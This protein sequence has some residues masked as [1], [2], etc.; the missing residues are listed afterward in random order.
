[1]LRYNLQLLFDHATVNLGISAE[2]GVAYKKRYNREF[3][4]F[5]NCVDVS[6]WSSF[7]KS[8]EV[9]DRFRIVY[10]GAATEDKELYSLQDIKNVVLSLNQKGFLVRFSIYGPPHYRN[11]IEKHL[12]FSPCLRA[13]VVSFLPA[14]VS[15]YL[16]VLRASVVS[17][18]FL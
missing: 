13:S 16:R 7:K 9:N 18:Y 15:Q 4:P 6:Y 8:Y 14:S 17:L 10:L 11:T 5:H 12:L 1:M 2:M 3:I